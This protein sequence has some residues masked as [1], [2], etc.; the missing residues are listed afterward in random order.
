MPV[1]L[2]NDAD[3]AAVGEATFGAGRAFADVVYITISTGMG[4]GVV[5]GGRLVHG[6]R[7]LA[8]IGHTDHRPLR[9]R[10]TVSQRPSRS[11]PPGTALA[12]HAAALG[13]EAEGAEL[14]A[15]VDG[16]TG[17]ARSGTTRSKLP[18][19][20]SPTSPTCSRP[21]WWW[22]AAASGAAARGCS[23][24]SAT[25]SQRTDRGATTQALLLSA[26]PS[27]TTPASSVQRVGH[28]QRPMFSPGRA[29]PMSLLNRPPERPVG[30]LQCDQRVLREA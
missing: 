30:S 8:E 2:A 13:L 5:L 9:R 19:S 15:L 18:A 27:A 7:S 1:A 6:A 12:S 3:M 17:P 28:R 11:L 26:P 29:D 25:S 24:R 4:A 22:S 14:V 21:R 20:P 23:L 16:T 10:P